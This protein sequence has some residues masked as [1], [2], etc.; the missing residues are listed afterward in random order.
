M[1]SWRFEA[2]AVEGSEG[3][4]GVEGVE[5][6]GGHVEGEGDSGDEVEEGASELPSSDWAYLDGTVSDGQQ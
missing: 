5:D 2:T 4:E 3:V 1:F 6:G